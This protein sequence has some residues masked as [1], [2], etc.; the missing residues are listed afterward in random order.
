M[1]GIVGVGGVFPV[2]ICDLCQIAAGVGV[3]RIGQLCAAC[4]LEADPVQQIVYVGKAVDPPGTVGDGIDQVCCRAF[5]GD[6]DGTFCCLI[7]LQ[8]C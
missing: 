7:I 2:L 1:T 5:I 6:G 3:G 4:A 8:L